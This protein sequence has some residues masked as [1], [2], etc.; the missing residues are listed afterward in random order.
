MKPSPEERRHMIEDFKA[1]P[2]SAEAIARKQR[3][4]GRLR[5]EGVPV[6]DVLPV[7]EDS[8]EAKHRTKEEIAKR[9]IAV[10]IAAVKGE[11]LE[12]EIIDSVIEQYGAESFFSP[13]EAAFIADLDPGEQD[14][15][16]F[17]WR[18]ECAWILFWALGYVESLSRADHHCD[19]PEL[20]SIFKNRNMEKFLED[21]RLRA[22]DEI[23]D[24]TDLIYRY[25]W[26][27]TNAR[28]NH[29]PAPAGLDGGVVKEWHYALN[30]LI[31]YM[32]EEWDDVSVDT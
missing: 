25:H 7:I 32:D 11:G 23:L 9:A 29:Q 19:V 8:G 13:E 4:I 12:Q 26:A 31:G 22:L 15:I 21:A 5:A 18:Y 24:E 17:G 6:L 3:S 30:W 1:K 10:F 28:I 16:N 27:A 2:P 14:R 20:V